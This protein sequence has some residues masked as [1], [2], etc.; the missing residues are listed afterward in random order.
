MLLYEKLKAVVA[1]LRHHDS[2]NFRGGSRKQALGRH[3]YAAWNL[4][5][6]NGNYN[7]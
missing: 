1:P 4:I 6:T 3:V 7:G 2:L 5:N